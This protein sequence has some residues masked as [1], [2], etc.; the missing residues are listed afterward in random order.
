[1]TILNTARLRLEPLDDRHFDGLYAINRIPEVMRYLTGKP[2][3][4]EQ[5][6][7]MI[8]RTKAQWA[9]HGYSWWALI[10]QEGG[11]MI[12]LGCIQNIE[13]NPVNPLEIGWR[14]RPDKWG[15][16][17][18]SE[19]AREM[20]RFAFETLDAQLLCAVC[21]QENGDSAAVMKRLGMS[22]ISIEHW[23]EMDV[24][25]YGMSRAKWL[26]DQQRGLASAR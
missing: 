14:L 4:P 5:T 17:Y 3:T 25:V 8:E 13:R 2:D 22:F 20:T 6:T 7:A 15:K 19:A 11:D 24:A 23:Y 16:G 1:M 18:A 9:Q 10:E 26:L 12:G 21:H